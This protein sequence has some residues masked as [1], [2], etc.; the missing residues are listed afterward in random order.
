MILIALLRFC[1]RKILSKT[2]FLEHFLPLKELL[3]ATFYETFA[4]T[5]G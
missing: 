2:K 4:L 5:S 3:V 1:F